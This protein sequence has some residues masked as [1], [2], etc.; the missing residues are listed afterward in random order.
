M[1]I[2]QRII[3]FFKEENLCNEDFFHYIKDKIILVPNTTEIFWYGCHPIIENNKIK[4]IRIVVPE[5]K[6][7]KDMLINLHEFTHAI[8][9]YEEIGAEWEERRQEREEK[10][11]KAEEKYL[12]KYKK[13]KIWTNVRKKYWQEK[14][15]NIK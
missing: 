14:Y 1:E 6:K 5:I 9:L 2:D 11:R 4:D 3:E 13:C 8:E 15:N 10:A 12:T 7:E